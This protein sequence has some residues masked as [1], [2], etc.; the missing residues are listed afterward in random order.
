M[1]AGSRRGGADTN[2]LARVAGVA[3][4]VAAVRL[5]IGLLGLGHRAMAVGMP[6]QVLA[7]CYVRLVPAIGGVLFVDLVVAVVLCILVDVEI[8]HRILQTGTR[9]ARVPTDRFGSVT[10]AWIR[11]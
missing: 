3:A 11:A 6:T 1:P 5:R 4:V 9:L 7:V 8:G 2:G 10:L